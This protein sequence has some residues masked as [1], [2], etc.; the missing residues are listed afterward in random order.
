MYFSK[1]QIA[2]IGVVLLL[3]GCA[4]LRT[5]YPPEWVLEP[6]RTYAPEQFLIGM[7]EADNRDQAERRAYAAVARVFSANVQAESID[8]ESYAVQETGRT[9]RT[10]RKLE[11]NHHTTITTSKIL[12][13]VEIVHTWHQPSTRKVVALAALDRQKAERAIMNRLKDLD[14]VIESHVFEGRSHKKKIQ[15]IRGYKQALTLLAN[16]KQVNADLHVI[17]NSGT[18]QPPP[19][20]I[21]E[22]RREFHDF[23]AKEFV[24][25]VAIEG[26]HHLEITRAILE[27]LTQEGLLGGASSFVGEGSLAET[28]D[29]MITGQGTYWSVD[30]PDPLFKYVR[31]CG[32]LSIYENPS[33]RLI[34]VI[35]KTGR[36]GHI[37]EKEATVRASR[38]M[39]EMLSQEVIHLL[40][41]SIFEE[42]NAASMRP[43]KSKG[44]PQ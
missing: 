27:S 7:G 12:E 4:W 15:R 18:S 34:G 43:R 33:H 22:I 40:T 5:D 10:K 3:N 20:R 1:K 24:V 31:W 36:E 32:D 30:I 37:T 19:Y 44:C 16:R 38:V 26:K 9:S 25:S 11:L 14:G 28:A 29:I 8:R 42:E 6:E 39:Q 41:R 13:N 35:S 23:I 21:P 17:R 2:G